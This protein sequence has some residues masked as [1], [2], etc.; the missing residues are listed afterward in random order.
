MSEERLL[1]L[2]YVFTSRCLV[3]TLPILR[4]NPNSLLYTDWLRSYI[5]TGG[6]PP[7]SSSWHQVP[8]SSRP[9]SLFVLQLKPYTHSLCVT[10]SLTRR[11]TC[12][13]WISLAFVKR[14]YYTSHMQHVIENSSFYNIYKSSTSRGFSKPIIPI[15]FTLCYNGSLLTWTAVKFKLFIFS[16]PGFA[17]PYATNIIILMIEYDRCMLPA[18]F[19]YIIVYIRKVENRVQIADRCVPWKISNG[20]ENL[21]LQA[22][23]FQE[24]GVRRKF[25]GGASIGNYWSN[26]RSMEG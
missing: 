22:L 8:W 11:R 5:T 17:L 12:I 2:L 18:Q 13:L 1:W 3:P 24:V 15:L 21:V 7:V 6:L 23:Q 9:E 19:C 26:Q 16:M 25:P 10:S 14:T 20:A 4:I